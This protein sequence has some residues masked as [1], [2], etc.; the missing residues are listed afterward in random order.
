MD[1]LTPEQR[2]KCMAAVRSNNTKP[3]VLVRKCLWRYGFRYRLNYN[4]LP[5]HP[6]IVLPKYRTCIFI[7]GC[8]WHGHRHCRFAKLP[9]TNRAFWEDKISKNRARDRKEYQKLKEI[10]WKV[11]VIWSCQLKPKTQDETLKSLLQMLVSIP[12]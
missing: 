8:F 12:Q 4:K 3:E 11:I 2:H 6:D 9:T 1:K 7:N 10:G 5:G